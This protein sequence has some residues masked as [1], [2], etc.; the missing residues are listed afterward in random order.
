MTA[1]QPDST[2]PSITET[3][4][5]SGRQAFVAPEW[6]PR[7]VFSAVL[8]VGLVLILVFSVPGGATPLLVGDVAKQNLRS[9]QRVAFVS[10]A[11]TKQAKDAAAATVSDV[12]D[13]D[14]GVA[15]QQRMQAT[16]LF[17]GVSNIRADPATAADQKRDRVSR[18]AEGI[19]L[20]TTA[21]SIMTIDDAAWTPVAAESMRVL[22]EV[23]R[24]RIRQADLVGIRGKLP[25]RFSSQ[26]SPQQLAVA[27][28]IVSD[29]VKPNEVL[30]PTET[31]KQKREAQD[32]VEPVREAV[33]K[34]EI[35]VRE[36]NVVTAL[37]LEKLQA[38]GLQQASSEW[39]D[40]VG[41]IMLAIIL[42]ALLS[43]YMTS[44]D[45]SLLKGDQRA[46]FL[47]LG[48][49][50]FAL[51][52][53]L[54]SSMRVVEG[55]TWIYLIPF[56]TLP[57]LVS[58]L[59]DEDVAVVMAVFMGIAAGF[60]SGRTLDIGVM[61]T[62]AGWVAALRARR[63]E[64]LSDFLLAGVLIALT[65][66]AT[67]LLFYLRYPEL[68]MTGLMVAL[69][70]ALFSGALAAALAVLT[71]GPL[72]NLLGVSTALHL[73][74]LAHPSQPLFRRLLLEAPG[75]YHHSVIIST[76][77]ERAAN[78]IGA[79]SLLVRVGAYYHD[80]G[81]TAR[82]Y[83]FIENQINGVN[84]HDK[85]DPRTSAKAIMAHVPEGIDLARKQRLPQAV[86]DMIPQHHGTKLAAY[87][88]AQ[89]RSQGEDVDESEFRYP[90]PK[91]QTKEA[92]ILMLADGV[93]AAVRSNRDHSQEVIERVVAEIAES[94][95]ADG[96]LN[97]SPLTLKDLDR[98]RSAFVEV[99][100]GVYHPRIAYPPAGQPAALLPPALAPEPALTAIVPARRP[101]AR[102]RG[103]THA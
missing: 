73:L 31:A 8:V 102:R 45:P 84:I 17:N 39:P 70:L 23:M 99:L 54:A 1:S 94:V 11:K 34:G 81:K 77:A 24:D 66:A 43:R 32:K 93:E 15:Q 19:V 41:A 2:Q 46:T 29:L 89:A 64:R 95:T 63:I 103:Q 79:D 16:V 5:E 38:A 51:A 20:P 49:L 37:D 86:I 47:A 85:L 75:T 71:F 36:G 26:L 68:D 48:I 61:V 92:A 90:G 87:F 74:E 52:G 44:V 12:Y 35:I 58:M 78:A 3:S 59:I 101:R 13:Y 98:I 53:R 91:P 6:L 69:L 60:A 9:P 62:L 55:V 56:A 96:Q 22:D 76:L 28:A 82:P 100:Q 42:V 4:A 33:E 67:V 72:G 14:P 21:R 18:L 80:I 83:L 10:Q 50:L 40:V 7:F 25:N 57:M 27:V 65:K 97:E 88:Y 30:N